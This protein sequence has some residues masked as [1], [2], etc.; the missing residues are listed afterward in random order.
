MSGIFVPFHAKPKPRANR[1]AK[2]GWITDANGCDIWQ[3]TTN[4]FGYGRVI[5]GGRRQS[6]HCVRYER[7]IGP[8]PEGMD[9]DHYVCDNGP[10]GCCNPF[11]CRPVSRRENVLRGTGRTAINAA[12]THCPK[13]HPLAKENLVKSH[14]ARTGSRKCRTCR[15]ARDLAR[16]YARK[17]RQAA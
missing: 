1:S 15:N 2:V 5:V 4:G 7:E 11:H 17:A 9:L 16:Y 12:K 13:G 6:V 8:I 10:G 3:G 14:F